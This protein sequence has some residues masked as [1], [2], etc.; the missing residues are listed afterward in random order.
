MDNIIENINQFIKKFDTLNGYDQYRKKLDYFQSD[1]H[2]YR[3]ILNIHN[4][5]IIL[6][7]NDN[8]D[9]SENDGLKRL[10]CKKMF[11]DKMTEMVSREVCFNDSNQLHISRFQYLV[12]TVYNNSITNYINE[13]NLIG[14]K[15]Q[16]SDIL[17]LYKG[18]TTMKIL[19]EKYKREL[20][21]HL[22]L[23]NFFD[24]IKKYFERSDSDYSIYINPAINV[25]EYGIDYND[26]YRDLNIMSY[27]NLDIIRKLIEVNKDQIVPFNLLTNDVLIDKVHKLNEMVRDV[28]TNISNC[29]DYANID[30]VLGITFNDKTCMIESIPNITI[31]DIDNTVFSDRVLSSKNKEI[32]AFIQ[33]KEVGSKKKDFYMTFVDKTNKYYKE[34]N[35]KHNIYMSINETNE[36]KNKDT[37]ATFSLHRLK[38]NFTIYY[39]TIDGKYRFFNAP[40]ELVD[41][42][43]LKKDATGLHLFYDHYNLEQ[44][45]YKYTYKNLSDNRDISV[46]YRG[47]TIFGHINDLLFT[48]FDVSD[49]P[50]EDIKYAKRIKRL[51]LFMFL[52]LCVVFNNNTKLIKT[53]IGQIYNFVCMDINEI[54]KIKNT[55]KDLAILFANLKHGDK[56][57]FYMFFTKIHNIYRNPKFKGE[58]DK[59][60]QMC[61]EIKELLG[62]L[63]DVRNVK[64][65]DESIYELVENVPMLGGKK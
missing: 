12:N 22:E 53:I 18:G 40:S 38:I 55:A 56:M 52:E 51:M 9:L 63:I 19:Y 35:E 60:I 3:S 25:A 39:R 1:K 47:Y 50:W 44:K 31:D 45:M 7:G 10:M 30:K 34:F 64:L 15:L 21:N 43:I 46:L 65:T 36:Y 57:A 17:F 61:S 29:D 33:N 54:V 11:F 62:G 26:V 5:G 2:E 13:K 6:T 37:L 42:S 16:N 24:S 14:A 58:I 48:L 4:E 49:F 23:N 27:T 41:V 32:V 20:G 59:Y 28:K 8:P